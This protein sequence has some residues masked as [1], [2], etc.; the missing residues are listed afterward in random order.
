MLDAPKS[1]KP[2]HV[3]ARW[4]EDAKVFV[5][6][7]DVPGLVVEAETFDEFVALVQ[8]LA[9]ELIAENLPDQPRPFRVRIDV[10]R[11]FVMADA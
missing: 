11:E 9:P 7:S 5:S 4:D 3:T 10:S 8:A 6:R 1:A 2:F